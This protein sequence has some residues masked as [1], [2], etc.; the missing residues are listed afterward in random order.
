VLL[1][2]RFLASMYRSL[3]TVCRRH[4]QAFLNQGRAFPVP[5]PRA[6]ERRG[7]RRVREK[8]A[9]GVRRPAAGSVGACG[10]DC[11]V[12]FLDIN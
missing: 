9:A 2:V 11:R 12:A 10:V 5:R 4:R 1:M 6:P 7:G 3:L 8:R